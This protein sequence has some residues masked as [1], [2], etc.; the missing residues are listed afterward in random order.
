MNLTEENFHYCLG[1]LI[2]LPHHDEG[3][4]MI[5]SENTDADEYDSLIIDKGADGKFR[6]VHFDRSGKLLKQYIINP[7]EFQLQFYPSGMRI[8]LVHGEDTIQ[9]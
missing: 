7:L 8:E 1:K 5:I 2:E 6:F 4:M 9:L 3:S